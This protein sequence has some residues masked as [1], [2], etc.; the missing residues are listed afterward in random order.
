MKSAFMRAVA[1]L[2]LALVPTMAAANDA[3]IGSEVAHSSMM[4]AT[5][6]N[7]TAI[8]NAFPHLVVYNGSGAEINTEALA[9]GYDGA[10]QGRVWWEAYDGLWL[11][12][13][14][15][16][17]DYGAQGANF[18][19]GG[20]LSNGFLSPSDYGSVIGGY[21]AIDHQWI[22]LGIAKPTSNGGAWAAGV[23]FGADQTKDSASDPEVENGGTAF[24]ANFS[25][26]NGEGLHVGAEFALQSEENQNFDPKLEGSFMNFA[27][28]GRYDTDLYI[29]QGSFV[30]GAGTVDETNDT[31]T[32]SSLFGFYASAG[33]YLKNEA[34]G[35]ATAEFSFAYMMMKDENGDADETDTMI[36]FPGVRVAAWEMITDRFGVMGAISSYYV[37][38]TNEENDGADPDPDTDFASKG[39]DYSWEAGLFFQPTDVVRI[40]FQ[41]VRD[42]LGYVLSLGNDEELVAYI[43]ATASY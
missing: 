32:D 7:T 29:Y 4:G 15:G 41:F 26:G 20:T 31:E 8:F 30:Y 9:S 28:N 25:W 35:Q 14:V 38:D 5:L 23:F 22:N 2:A 19:W 10:P 13:S 36:I 40:D 11:N 39:M 3:T 6:M 33:R 1:V 21:D 12:L 18:M 17:A 16:R 27:L 24:G 34:T 42:N 37:L 43:G